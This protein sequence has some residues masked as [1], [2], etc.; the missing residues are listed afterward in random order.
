MSTKQTLVQ[1]DTFHLY[2]EPYDEDGLFLAIDTTQADVGATCAGIHAVVRIPFEVWN[3]IC[4]IGP[5]APRD[6]NDDEAMMYPPP[7]PLME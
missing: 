1:G 6:F 2:A 3:Q 5:L 7:V 4:A